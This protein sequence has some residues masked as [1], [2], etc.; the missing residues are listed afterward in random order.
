MY[1]I[2]YLLLICML[3]TTIM[4]IMNIIISKKKYLDREKSSPFECGFDP[5]STPRTPFSLRFYLIS[6]I[7]LIFDIEIVILFPLMPSMWFSNPMIWLLM[8]MTF[9]I[10]LIWGVFIEWNDGSLMWMK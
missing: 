9:S 6:I 3:L 10:L 5:L 8:F 1:M 2:M 4:M 7:F